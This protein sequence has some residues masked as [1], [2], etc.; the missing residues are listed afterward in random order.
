MNGEPKRI[1]HKLFQEVLSSEETKVKS[2]HNRSGG[3]KVNKTLS[4]AGKSTEGLNT[5]G[6]VSGLQRGLELHW[7]MYEYILDFVGG[8]KATQ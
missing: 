2:F 3:N 8:R 4:Q 5:K 7:S 6:L 1:C